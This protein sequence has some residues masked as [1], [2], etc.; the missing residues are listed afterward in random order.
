MV[1]KLIYLLFVVLLSACSN[2][3]AVIQKKPCEYQTIN[4]EEILV[5]TEQ[6]QSAYYK[7]G[8]KYK[9]CKSFSYI[10][11]VD[12]KYEE[13]SGIKCFINGKWNIVK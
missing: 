2:N 4:G 7:N 8:V 12:E 5:C 9:N 3:Q 10:S 6:S 13:N 1:D 11:T